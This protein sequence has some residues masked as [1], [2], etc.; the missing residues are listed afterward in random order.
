MPRLL[1]LAA[2]ALILSLAGCDAPAPPITLPP[3]PTTTPVFASDEEALAAAEEAYRAYLAV[4]D[5]ILQAGGRDPQRIYD[6]ATRSVGDDEQAGFSQFMRDGY[7]SVGSTTFEPAQLELV[8]TSSEID[9][10]RIYVCTDSSG[11]DVVDEYGKSVVAPTRQT[12]VAFEIGFDFVGSSLLMS[13]KS[14]WD[15][16]AVCE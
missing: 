10:V 3:T 5:A 1:H 11:V 12:R 15:G 16:G 7:R 2:A 8:R 14:V 6:V 9:V 4:S 13:S